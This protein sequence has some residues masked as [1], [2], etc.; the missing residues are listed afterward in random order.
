ME[1]FAKKAKEAYRTE[2]STSSAIKKLKSDSQSVGEHVKVGVVPL[3]RLKYAE[4]TSVIHIPMHALFLGL[5]KQVC[6]LISENAACTR[7]RN[8]AELNRVVGR[9]VDDIQGI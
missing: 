6:K 4:T 5:V 2:G 1:Y 8:L 3:S 7:G 9:A